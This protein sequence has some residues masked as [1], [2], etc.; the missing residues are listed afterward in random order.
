ML[1]HEDFRAMEL[2]S[3]KRVVGLAS[4]SVR[5]REESI[6]HVGG[7]EVCFTRAEGLP[8]VTARY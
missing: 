4:A 2:I 5:A 6:P 7:L 8:W 3:E 1:K